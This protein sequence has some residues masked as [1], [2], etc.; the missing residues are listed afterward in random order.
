MKQNISAPFTIS[1][2][3]RNSTCFF[4][5]QPGLSYTQMLIDG[6]LDTPTICPLTSFVTGFNFF[7]PNW[8]HFE[9]NIRY[10]IGEHLTGAD[11]TNISELSL[12][13][14]LGLNLNV[15]KKHK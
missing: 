3:T 5:F 8:F 2:Q 10:T 14:G 11:E 6:S 13:F 12:N 9:F 1:Y 7:A 15:L 4:G